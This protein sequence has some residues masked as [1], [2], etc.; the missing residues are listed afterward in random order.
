MLVI[1]VAVKNAVLDALEF[2]MRVVKIFAV[3]DAKAAVETA[4]K[5]AQAAVLKVVNRR[6]EAVYVLL[7][8]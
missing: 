2:V 7:V 4:L 6:V 5:V 3:E 8:V 1:L